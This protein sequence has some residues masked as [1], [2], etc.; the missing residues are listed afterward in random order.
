[1]V[2]Y[3]FDKG[4]GYRGYFFEVNLVAEIVRKVGGD[5][6]LEKKYHLTD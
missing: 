5:P 2:S 4:D 3:H 1:M 6:E